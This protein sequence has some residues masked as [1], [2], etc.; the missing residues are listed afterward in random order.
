MTDGSQPR[1]PAPTAPASDAAQ[2]ADAAAAS[3]TR[4]G[5]GDFARR[6]R[7][8]LAYFAVLL[9]VL[10]VPKIV[11]TAV[12]H[13]TSID[14]GYYTDIARH[15]R[16]GD[17]FVTCVSLYHQGFPAFP[18]P[19]TVYPLWP[20]LYGLAA[21][22]GGPLPEV[23]T[24]LATVF[25][26]ASLI[27]AYLWGRAFDDR[28]LFPAVAPG[29]GFGHLAMLA[30]GAH[31]E[32]FEFTS[33]PYTE[34]LAFSLTFA[35][36]WRALRRL[37]RPSVLGGLECGLWA[38]LAFL[39]RTQLALLPASFALTC[40]AF[41]L[42][43]RRRLAFARCL[44]GFAVAFAACVAPYY[45]HVRNLVVVDPWLAMLRF[46]AA[47]VTEGLSFVPML[48]ET[49]GPLAYLTDRLAGVA[50][51]FHPTGRYAYVR[52]F[53]PLAWTLPAAVAV[54]AIDAVDTLRRQGRERPSI[55]H[56][57]ARRIAAAQPAGL[58]VLVLAVAAT[59]SLHT[60]HKQYYVPWNFARRQ[61]LVVVFAFLLAARHLARH[62]WGWA[63]L[64]ALVLVAGTL[65]SGVRGALGIAKKRVDKP[66][67]TGRPGYRRAL[68][69]WLSERRTI[70]GDLVVAMTAQEPQKI[71]W[72]T[73][74]IGYHWIYKTTKPRDLAILAERL[75]ARYVLVHRDAAKWKLFHSDVF[76][77]LFVPEDGGRPRYVSGYRIYRRRT[78]GHA[79]TVKERDVGR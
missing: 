28:D 8:Q 53:G 29:F 44:A 27:L 23:G 55:G 9:L 34:G 47:H 18:H 11:A 43:R 64:L 66:D 30:V 12:E 5:H 65:T 33:W 48:V 60:I 36:L 72:R 78:E 13:G 22:L 57:I 25:Y 41:V 50:Q 17:G 67:A 59:V 69:E 4:P 71:A 31:R 68:I 38:G 70:E 75:G 3:P 56:R 37:S 19:T 7:T 62:R 63:R 26:F 14:G 79:P 42:D 46:D 77:R 40:G 76:D 74:G 51:A 35:F 61:A 20:L 21:R 54:V 16:D 32:Y 10:G 58:L 15:L 73:T 2:P 49:D 1:P 52:A 39:A 24:Y 6:R 45:L